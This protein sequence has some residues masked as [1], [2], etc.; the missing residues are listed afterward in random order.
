MWEP[1]YDPLEEDV[2]DRINEGL[3]QIEQKYI[4]VID[5]MTDILDYFRERLEL[6]ELVDKPGSRIMTCVDDCAELLSSLQTKIEEGDEKAVL[7][8]GMI[9]RMYDVIVRCKYNCDTYF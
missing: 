5:D 9:Q 1:H 4:K 3:E 6:G 2:R 8:G 7:L